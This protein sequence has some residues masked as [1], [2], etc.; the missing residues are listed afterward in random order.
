[1]H[2]QRSG[3]TVFLEKLVAQMRVEPFAIAIDGSNDCGVEKMNPLTVC[4]FNGS[5]G[6]VVQQFLDMCMSSSSTAEGLF[7]TMKEAFSKHSLLWNNCVGVSMDNTAVNMGKRNS[8]MTRVA[9][10]NPS[11]YIMGCPCH[12]VH[13]TAVKAADAFESV[14]VWP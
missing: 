14:S 12:I 6:K 13:N 7:T 8:I 9:Q 3:C 5:T 10:E 2:S 11:V 1:M 4:I